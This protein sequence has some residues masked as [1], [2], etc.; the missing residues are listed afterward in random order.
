MVLVLLSIISVCW[1]LAWNSKLENQVY[2]KMF[3]TTARFYSLFFEFS[4]FH[5]PWLDNFLLLNAT[6]VKREAPVPFSWMLATHLMCLMSHAQIK[7]LCLFLPLL[8]NGT[9]VG[10]PRG[11][12]KSQ[13]I[14]FPRKAL[15]GPPS[16]GI[17]PLAPKGGPSDIYFPVCFHLISHFWLLWYEVS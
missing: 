4:N 6:C 14:Y 15:W 16:L 7:K 11:A 10:G 8:P 3:C 17:P 1:G 5:V 2:S 12:R 9:G 13:G